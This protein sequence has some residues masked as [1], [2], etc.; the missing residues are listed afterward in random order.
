MSLQRAIEQQTI[1]TRDQKGDLP[2]ERPL[3][4][5]TKATSICLEGQVQSL[6]CGCRS[7][8]PQEGFQTSQ[9]LVKYF[10]LLGI[11][12]YPPI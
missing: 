10:L 3:A 1:I 2:E 9:Q 4:S 7:C 5:D 6:R 8:V 11:G 12:C